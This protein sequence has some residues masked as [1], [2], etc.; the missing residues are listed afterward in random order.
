MQINLVKESNLTIAAMNGVKSFVPFAVGYG[1]TY[2]IDKIAHKYF[3][4]ARGTT[5]S[6]IAEFFA[7]GMGIAASICVIQYLPLTKIASYPAVQTAG[8]VVVAF[9]AGVIFEKIFP[10]AP[11][12]ADGIILGILPPD[13]KLIYLGIRG[14]IGALR[15]FNSSSTAN[16]KV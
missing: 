5:N 6:K 14:T 3:E 13:L 11:I 4:L 7:I 8:I 10:P 1:V 15:G 16:V 12:L 9:L 2:A